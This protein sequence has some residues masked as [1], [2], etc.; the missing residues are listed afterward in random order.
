MSIAI[1]SDEFLTVLLSTRKIRKDAHALIK[2]L[3][4]KKAGAHGV[5][6]GSFRR[7]IGPGQVWTSCW[8]KLSP[9]SP[10]ARQSIRKAV[11]IRHQFAR[12]NFRNHRTCKGPHLQ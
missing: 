9:I 6:W 10:M 4:Q 5:C 8:R 2:T 1:I 12:R 3:C 11:A 7:R